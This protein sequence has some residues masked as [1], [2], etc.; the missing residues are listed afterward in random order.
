MKNLLDLQ[1]SIPCLDELTTRKLLG[2]DGY[3]PTNPPEFDYSNELPE[4][5]LNL[6]PL[7]PEE[8]NLHD[9]G[10]YDG[11]PAGFETDYEIQYP[12][13]EQVQVP[14]END[15]IDERD[16]KS[17][18]ENNESDWEN[19]Q[20]YKDD[21]NELNND[22]NWDGQDTSDYT[23]EEHLRNEDRDSNGRPDWAD[24]LLSRV[25]PPLAEYA[26]YL[27]IIFFTDPNLG[28]A[29][30]TY[31]NHE[32][33]LKNNEINDANIIYL[34]H[35]LIHAIQDSI[36]MLNDKGM[37]NVEFQTHLLTDLIRTVHTGNQLNTA[38]PLLTEEANQEYKNWLSSLINI[39]D[40]FNKE[41]FESKWQSY[42][43]YFIEQ[44]KNIEGYQ[45]VD[46]NFN[47][48]WDKFIEILFFK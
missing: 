7:D 30:G 24:T 8:S 33:T 22:S 15:Q 6:P 37:A 31:Q 12:D 46:E 28:E 41:L 42:F 35:E 21:Q 5:D 13:M 43:P 47:W 40:T 14:S 9:P 17:D 18:L 10:I 19:E 27:D 39:D 48:H 25:F 16:D 45:G 32:I 44:H 34:T 23:E 29:V 4:F 36:G 1:L 11:P 3:V 2:G 20:N 38:L 26:E